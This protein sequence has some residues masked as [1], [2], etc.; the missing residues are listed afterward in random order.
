MHGAA[1]ISHVTMTENA[2][3]CADV[4]KHGGVALLVAAYGAWADDEEVE[5]VV[6]ETL[7]N[8]GA[9]EDPVTVEKLKMSEAAAAY[10]AVCKEVHEHGDFA[11]HRLAVEAFGGDGEKMV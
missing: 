9:L 7:N 2:A 5:G 11:L 4:V 1:G 6:L 3:V 10:A 8:L